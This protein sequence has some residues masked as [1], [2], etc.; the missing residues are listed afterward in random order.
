[1]KLKVTITGENVHNVGYRYFLMTSAIDQGLDGF[2]ARNTMKGNEQQV[3]ALIEG[4]E[5][6][7]AG[8]KKLAES[9]RPEHSL[10]SSIVFEDTNSNV[11]K[12]GEYAQVCTAIQL[13]KAIPLLLDMRDDMKEMKGDIKEMK[14]DMKEMKGDMKEMK[15][16]MKEMKGDMKVVRK[17]TDIIP[18]IHE[19]IKGMREDIQ[20]GYAAQFRL[21]QA[22]IRAIKE[23]LGM[24]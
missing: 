14:G 8:F 18:Q 11:M 16:D 21:V 9:Q 19:E 10:V 22:D 23:R 7:I 2:N 24:S 3:V 13:N 12:T 4:N 5:E 1:M 17:N 6:A 15:G 20:P